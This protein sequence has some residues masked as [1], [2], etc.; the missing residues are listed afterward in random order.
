M[1]P[2]GNVAFCGWKHKKTRSHVG[3][4]LEEGGSGPVLVA[5]THPRLRTV[6]WTTVHFARCLET[7][8]G[9]E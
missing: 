4:P 6:L 7:S 8:D 1:N 3:Y 5:R 9:P 2:A